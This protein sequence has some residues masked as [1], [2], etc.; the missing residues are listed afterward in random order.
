[1]AS[2]SRS[3]KPC[4][5]THLSSPT[6][7][8]EAGSKTGFIVTLGLLTA[9]SLACLLFGHLITAATA[10]PLVRR[11]TRRLGDAPVNIDE[12][13][14]RFLSVVP[15]A[16]Q[17]KARRALA[18]VLPAYAAGSIFNADYKEAKDRLNHLVDEAYEESVRKPFLWGK[19][20]TPE[21]QIEQ[22]VGSVY[23]LYSIISVA[24]KV[25]KVNPPGAYGDALRSFV[26]ASLPLAQIMNELKAR[27]VM[28]RKPN[29]EA[30]AKR[31]AVEAKKTMRTCACCF[32]SIAVLPNGLIADHGYRLPSQWMKTPSCP[33]GRFRPLEVSSDGLKYMVNWMTS[34][35]EA[36]SRSLS[37][38]GDLKSI[39]TTNWRGDK[40]VITP[41]SQSW[42][43]AFQNHKKDLELDLEMT[44]R[45]LADYKARLASWEPASASR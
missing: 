35:A 27:V 22:K 45:S 18:I 1:M 42:S 20:Y 40:I 39:T 24:K 38:V 14:A 30:A 10:G 23:G 32:R 11:K 43:L 31:A 33:G 17:E 36:L 3:L 12:A 19:G 9:G 8:T 13:A 29:P 37:S 26:A 16:R 21:Y 6:E 44:Q 34:R 41:E 15:A 25:E 7:E 5:S 2:M 28:G 4:C